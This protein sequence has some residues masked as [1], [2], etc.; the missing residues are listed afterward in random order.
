MSQKKP[1]LSRI[2]HYTGETIKRIDMFGVPVTLNFRGEDK[3]KTTIGGIISILAFCFV[4]WYTIT[5]SISIIE[6]ENTV[7]NTNKAKANLVLDREIHKLSEKGISLNV[8]NINFTGTQ[9]P[10]ILDSSYFGVKYINEIVEINETTRQPMRVENKDLGSKR[11][12]ILEEDMIE[13]EV[14]LALK[15]DQ[16]Y[17]PVSNDY[18]IGG[19]QLGVLN[20]QMIISVRRWELASG[21]QT[22]ATIDADM[23]GQRVGLGIT[24]FY[25]DVE[26][27]E[28]PI[29]ALFV[30][31]FDVAF[32][33]GYTVEKHLKVK[34]N[35]VTDYTNLWHGFSP[36]EYLFYSIDS[37]FDVIEPENGSGDL[38]RFKLVLDNEFNIIERKVYTVYDMLG[39]VGGLMG[40]AISVGS[41]L[42]GMF[43]NNVYIMTL[44]SYFYKVNTMKFTSKAILSKMF[45]SKSDGRLND[46][47]YEKLRKTRRNADEDERKNDEEIKTVS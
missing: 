15:L 17:C 5:Q 46:E 41:L 21:W 35:R 44:L 14:A 13:P 45:S 19:T 11:W 47:D 31:D 3:F 26:D 30:N 28:S 1:F 7:I 43:S 34:I 27:Y 38:V 36:K 24:N 37:S 25:F 20:H 10:W 16:F 39:Q 23:V 8:G 40:L 33:P 32:L 12:G 6:R 22:T 18:T 29:K 9:T 42:A 2:G 4:L